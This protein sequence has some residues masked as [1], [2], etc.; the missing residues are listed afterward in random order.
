MLKMV[1]ILAG[2]VVAASVVLFGNRGLVALLRGAP[3]RRK[4]IKDRFSATSNSS[5]L[6]G[7]PASYPESI[8]GI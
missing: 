8:D 4:L 7:I 5:L 6:I 1:G 3:D 2:I